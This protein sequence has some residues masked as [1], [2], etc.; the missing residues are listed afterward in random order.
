MGKMDYFSR[1]FIIY[2]CHLQFC[3]H[4]KLSIIPTVLVNK[5]DKLGNSFINKELCEFIGPPF[6]SRYWTFDDI[7]IEQTDKLSLILFFEIYPNLFTIW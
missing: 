7:Y 1:N 2:V 4:G 5:T 3:S 6:V